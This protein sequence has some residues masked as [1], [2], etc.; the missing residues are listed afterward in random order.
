MDTM[1]D[2]VLHDTEQVVTLVN[3]A[4]SRIHTA[5][6]ITVTVKYTTEGETESTITGGS[7][8]DGGSGS[9]QGNLIV[10]P[11]LAASGGVFSSGQLIYAREAGPEIIGSFGAGRTGIMNNDQIVDSVSNGVYQA[12]VD[13]MARCRRR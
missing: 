11:E 12:M 6:T 5:L 10:I 8:S 13:A 7:K 4:L 1:L 3:D 9:G 2:G